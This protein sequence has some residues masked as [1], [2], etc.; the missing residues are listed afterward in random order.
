M[1]SSDSLQRFLFEHAAIRGELVHLDATWR[2]ALERHDYPPPVRGLLGELM[3]AAALLSATLKFNG[4]LTLQIQGNGP[5]GLAVVEATS[6]RTPAPN[7]STAVSGWPRT[8][9]TPP[10]C[11]CNACRTGATKTPTPGTAPPTSAPP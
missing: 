2:A 8:P 3:A 4:S 6:E 9:V 11:C 1:T 5:V 7:S 10:A